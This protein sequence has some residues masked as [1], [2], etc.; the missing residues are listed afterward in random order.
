MHHHKSE[1]SNSKREKQRKPKTPKKITPTYLHNSGLYYL[2]RFSAS[3]KHFITVMSRKAKR[4]C[5]HHTD[6]NYDECIQMVHELADKFEKVGLLN[7]DL[8]TNGLVNSLRR[9]GKSEKA[10]I[11]KMHVKGID[12]EKTVNALKALDND[13]FETPQEAELYAAMKL[14]RKKRIGPFFQGDE[15]NVQKSLGVF[16]RAGFSYDISKQVIDMDDDRFEEYQ[17]KHGFF[18]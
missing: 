1:Q 6:Q 14:A 7:D 17:Q 3:K 13:L 5:M 12:P 4:S 10:I 18:F 9:K 11:S 8:Y 16:A 2:E 15:E